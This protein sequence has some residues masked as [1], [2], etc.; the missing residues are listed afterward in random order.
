VVVLLVVVVVCEGSTKR[1]A[2]SYCPVPVTV[3]LRFGYF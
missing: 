2:P 3:R 1:R